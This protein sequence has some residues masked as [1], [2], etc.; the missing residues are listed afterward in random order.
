[1]MNST[2]ALI[3]SASARWSAMA[4]EDDTVASLSIQR[5]TKHL[6]TPRFRIRRYDETDLP[7]VATVTKMKDGR[8]GEQ[9]ASKTRQV[10][11]EH[12]RRGIPRT[13]VVLDATDPPP[14]AAPKLSKG[15]AIFKAC[16]ITL[17]D[18]GMTFKHGDHDA[19]IVEDVRKM[20]NKLYEHNGNSVRRKAESSAWNRAFA[21]AR[22]VGVVGFATIEVECQPTDILWLIAQ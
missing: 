1:M 2:N 4:N 15:L 16:V 7:V 13:S 10:M 11:L 5:H 9:I 14:K 6:P 3:I 21:K 19:V 18:K 17:I 22:E 8:T 12:D 20:H